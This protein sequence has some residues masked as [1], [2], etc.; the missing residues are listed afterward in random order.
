MVPDPKNWTYRLRGIKEDKNR[1]LSFCSYKCQQEYLGKFPD[2][3]EYNVG[4]KNKGVKP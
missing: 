2:R 3:K 4:F 1:V